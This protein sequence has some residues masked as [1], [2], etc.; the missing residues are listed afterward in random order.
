MNCIQTNAFK[1]MT[2]LTVLKQ[3][4]NIKLCYAQIF[5]Q[6]KVGSGQVLIAQEK[7]LSRIDFNKTKNYRTASTV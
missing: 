3:K 4:R 5:F 1:H 2:L 7:N 6:L